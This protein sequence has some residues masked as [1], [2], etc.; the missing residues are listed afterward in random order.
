MRKG[1]TIA[2][3]LLAG[4]GFW[5]LFGDRS[6]STRHSPAAERAIQAEREFRE[7]LRQSGRIVFT[8]ES[9]RSGKT[10]LWIMDGDGSQQSALTKSGLDLRPAWS[11]GGTRVAF[12]RRDPELEDTG[13]IYLLDLSGGPPRK[14]SDTPAV[15]HAAP[16]WSPDDRFIAFT[17][18]ARDEAVLHYEVRLVEVKSGREVLVGHGEH[19]SWSPDGRLVASFLGIVDPAAAKEAARVRIP[20][21]DG[22]TW[23]TD[24]RTI[25]FLRAVRGGSYA[26]RLHT[27]DAEGN[28]LKSLTRHD[29]ID[30]RPAWSPEGRR[31]GFHSVPPWDELGKDVE[32]HVVE[33]DGTASRSLGRGTD[34]VWTPEGNGLIFSAL[35]ED[36]GPSQI[37]YIDADGR[38]R[39]NLS[40]SDA[41]DS[42][43]QIHR[44]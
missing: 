32:L 38:R 20:E 26:C 16:C 13:R 5:I 40:Q 23:S 4:A 21:G 39:T 31:L 17:H 28:L 27:L 9:G 41:A 14:L 22:F 25:A 19:P 44:R 37:W 12:V 18:P 2:L 29:R 35:R 24:G 1:P 42:Q 6:P 36:D 3:S 10:D 33:A 43:P 30:Q 34:P 7:G 15:A 8:R 11:A